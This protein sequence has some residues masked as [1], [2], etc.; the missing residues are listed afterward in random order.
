[1]TADASS[2]SHVDTQAAPAATL[3]AAFVMEQDVGHAVQALHLRR[4]L[5]AIEGIEWDYVPVSFYQ[6]GGLLEKLPL[7]ATIR[8]SLRARFEVK[9]GLGRRLPDAMLWNTQKPAVFCQGLL[10]QVPSAI[11]LDVTPKQYDEIGEEYGHRPD[12]FPPLRAAKHALNRRL[13]SKARR[14]LPAT[15]WVARSLVDDYDV[16][17]ERIEVLPPGTDLT[18]FTPVGR[19]PSEDDGV[20]RVLFVGGDFHRK[21]GDVLLDWYRNAAPEKVELNLVTRDAVS[22]PPGVRIHR[23][24]YGDAEL[25]RLYRE[26]DVFALPSRAECFGLVLSEALAC[27][28]P[29]VTCPVGGLPEV[30]QDGVTGLMV[31]PGDAVSL[32]EAMSALLAD[33]SLRRRLGEAGRKD[34]EQRFDA[35]RNVRRMVE[36]LREVAADGAAKR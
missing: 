6:R 20:L 16:L 3:Y 31:R 15:D 23:L 13:F 24:D 4:E 21:G 12:G 25:T 26:A 19:R 35:R 18:R 28:V 29:C 22:P 32:G 11:T 9:A 10:D 33:A 8:A 14:L 36:V 7:P 27:G 30:V 5:A 1:V 2:R 17:A 34:A